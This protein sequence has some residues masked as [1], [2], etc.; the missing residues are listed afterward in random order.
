MASLP[1]GTSSPSAF[2]FSSPTHLEAFSRMQFLVDEKRRM[3]LILGNRGNGKTLVLDMLAGD[4]RARGI[5]TVSV[6]LVD[7]DV[8]ELL[9]IM[10]TQLG[11]PTGRNKTVGEL[12]RAILDRLAANAYQHLRTVA[13]LDDVDKA[14]N[15]VFNHIIRLARH[16]PTP[17]AA[18]TMVLAADQTGAS[19]LMSR[20]IDLVDLR[21]ELEPWD[22]WETAHEA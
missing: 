14:P 21:T 7:L 22:A 6:S 15:D 5:P 9:W 20:L 2:F 16:N 4:F 11:A 18:L 12:W 10:A 1:S 17:P 19:R 8:R 3:G 13:L